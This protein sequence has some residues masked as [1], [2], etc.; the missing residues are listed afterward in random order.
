MVF[1]S[2]R[3]RLRLPH[4]PPLDS[5]H[6]PLR[7][8]TDSK[9]PQRALPGCTQ[10]ALSS[11]YLPTTLQRVV[12]PEFAG[13]LIGYARTRVLYTT[14]AATGAKPHSA[15]IGASVAPRGAGVDSDLGIVRRIYLFL[16]SNFF[17]RF[18]IGRSFFRPISCQKTALTT[19]A[20]L[21]S[22]SDKST[23]G[24]MD[25]VM[26]AVYLKGDP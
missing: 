12:Y 7:V 26:W 19:K 5:C 10:P 20:P 16:L 24:V 25:R 15:G 9:P 2:R 11:P 3:R 4:K 21:L 18:S 6:S 14:T 23:G 8:S 17:S 13:S 1:C 22:L